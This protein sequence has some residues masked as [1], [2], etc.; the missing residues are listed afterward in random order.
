MDEL[1]VNTSSDKENFRLDIAVVDLPAV[2][3]FT[4]KGDAVSGAMPEGR[5][6]IGLNIP[7]T[8]GFSM[9]GEGVDTRHYH[10]IG[11]DRPLEI[12]I[13]LS[14][15]LAA[16]FFTGTARAT[17]HALA[18]CE[19]P[20]IGAQTR[21]QGDPNFASLKSLLEYGMSEYFSE[22][23]FFRSPRVQSEYGELLYLALANTLCP[24][25][26]TYRKPRLRALA[27][28][29]D[30]VLSNPALPFSR[31]ELAQVAGV[32]IRTLT[33]LFVQRYG[34]G[35]MAWVR[36]NR[37]HRARQ[38]LLSG[39]PDRGVTDIA[40]ESGYFNPSTFTR[41][42]REEFGELPSE[43]RRKHRL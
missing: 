26:S 29:E 16:S 1:S 34:M 28:A 38:Q 5:D 32:S 6:F 23:D 39:D 43:T 20:A 10:L 15:L 42:Y 13:P 31:A 27:L 24:E 18:D 8:Q 12:A 33:R 30:Y 4:L 9:L 37:L 21:D 3:A 36:Q 17:V 11:P 40:L 2:V 35:P 22:S 25:G 19:L 41:R 14:D 7:I